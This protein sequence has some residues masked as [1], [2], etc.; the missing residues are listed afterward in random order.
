MICSRTHWFCEWFTS[1]SRWR[2]LYFIVCLRA[3][4][5]LTERKR[6]RQRVR[7]SVLNRQKVNSDVSAYHKSSRS[8]CL[9][10]FNTIFFQLPT[11]SASC[12]PKQGGGHTTHRLKTWKDNV[13]YRDY[14][15]AHIL[16][17]IVRCNIHNEEIIA[18]FLLNI[19]PAPQ[20]AAFWYQQPI[21]NVCCSMQH[22]H[23]S[24]GV[25]FVP[26][27]QHTCLGSGSGCSP[28]VLSHHQ[29]R[30]KHLQLNS[31]E[32]ISCK[33]SAFSCSDV[34]KSLTHVCVYPLIQIHLF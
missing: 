1:R 14:N 11:S 8:L 9:S 34:A 31:R 17:S 10:P 5:W 3:S 4:V 13:M 26:I 12:M 22:R 28:L 24:T 6:E 2:T 19:V 32:D 29:L 16:G 27:Q 23:L 15:A 18:S 33:K 30:I 20:S 7:A 25:L 21:I